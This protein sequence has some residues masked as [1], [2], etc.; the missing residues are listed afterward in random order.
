MAGGNFQPALG[1]LQPPINGYR[2]RPLPA[3]VQQ[4]HNAMVHLDPLA[5]DGDSDSETEV[6]DQDQ[7]MSDTEG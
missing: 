3:N 5:S 7:E 1:L 2:W 6:A 4:A